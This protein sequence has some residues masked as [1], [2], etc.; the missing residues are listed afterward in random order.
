MIYEDRV[1]EVTTAKRGS[2]GVECFHSSIQ[3]YRV[4]QG[5]T[6]LGKGEYNKT[7]KYRI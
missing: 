2:V 3:Q 7:G 4:G 5:S 1:A 6:V